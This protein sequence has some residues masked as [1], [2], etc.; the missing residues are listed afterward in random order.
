[1]KIGLSRTENPEKHQFYIDWL[2]KEPDVD[3]VTLSEAENNL[4]DLA[5]CDG[6]VLSGGIDIHPRFY[7]SDSVK[8]PGAPAEFKPLR[9]QFETDAFW[10]AQEKNIPV[11]GICRGLQM[12]NVILKGTLRQ[13]L[14]P[15]SDGTRHLG[16]PDQLHPVQA[17]PGTILFEFTQG[18]AE[19]VN[20]AHHQ[21]IERLGEGLRSS[22]H[23]LDGTIEAVEW[24]DKK[25][26]P[27][28]LAIQWHP[29]RM[30]RFNLEN[31]PLSKNLRERF[32]R[33]LKKGNS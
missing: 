29:E 9:D 22:C 32:F 12:I 15:F 19:I 5:S 16:N 8:Y 23:A 18:K 3:V 6:L 11:L 31:S 13:D 1:L 24:A 17:E 30:F 4:S 20:S 14:G 28:M 25:N 21:A 7:F 33:E 26:K 27:F 10:L 2:K